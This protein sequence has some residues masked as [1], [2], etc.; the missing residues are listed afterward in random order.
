V[1]AI[2]FVL[3]LVPTP[4][5]HMYEV[6]ANTVRVGE[7]IEFGGRD[8]RVLDVQGSHALI[9]H[10]TVITERPYH[11]LWEDVTWETSSSRAWL[12][13]EFFNSFSAED[14][15]RIRETNVINDDNP[16]TFFELRGNWN[17]TAGGANTTDRIFSLSIEEVVRYFGDSGMLAVGADENNRDMYTEYHH[18]NHGIYNFG[19]HDQ[20]SHARIARNEE[21]SA[22]WWW[23]R[24]SG[25]IPSYATY[26]HDDG[27]LRVDG[28]D[29]DV[30]PSG[31][32]LRPA[33][34]LILESPSPFPVP[35]I[36]SVIAVAALVGG[37]WFM[38]SHSKKHAKPK[39]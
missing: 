23:L 36:I 10:E 33:L 15:E 22:S 1:F 31:G 28:F 11:R 39:I 4:A 2:I 20:Y 13:D 25:F 5:V 26:V 38:Y 35:V 9:L 3:A 19:I 21:G 24:S 30:S 37:F 18:P 12:N 34:W 6:R 32:G 17:K 27:S 8:W 7:T 14:R 16:W 29:V